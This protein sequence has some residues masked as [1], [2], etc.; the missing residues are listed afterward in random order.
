MHVCNQSYWDKASQETYKRL[1][2]SITRLNIIEHY[3]A[4]EINPR[5]S[6]HHG[7]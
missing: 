6:E 3:E 5:M 2:E 1:M 4:L 7:G